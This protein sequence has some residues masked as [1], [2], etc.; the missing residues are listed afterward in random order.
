MHVA[1]CLYTQRVGLDILRT[2]GTSAVKS[3]GPY[4]FCWLGAPTSN[5]T[6]IVFKGCRNSN[7]LL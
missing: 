7:L 5:M 2:G 6:K 1:E 3:E 4:L